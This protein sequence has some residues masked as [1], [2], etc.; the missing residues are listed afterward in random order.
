MYSPGITKRRGHGGAEVG[1]VSRRT[2]L[3]GAAAAGTL[4]LLAPASKVLG[5]N[6]R[7]RI[8]VCGVRGRGNG[9]MRNF[10]DIDGVE[11]AWIVDPDVRQLLQRSEQ[12]EERTGKKPQTTTDVRH[13]L[14]DRNV[15]AIV[16]GAPNHWHALM[17][18]WAA[19]AGKHCYVEK[20]ASHDVYEG[21]VALEE[22]LTTLTRHCWAGRLAP[23]SAI[24]NLR[25]SIH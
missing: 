18:I 17:V 2:L 8:A 11:V 13:A 9:L 5:A 20:P 14:E 7:F 21:R 25:Q 15:D 4:G 3:Q 19:Q 12:M 6:D 10:A 24:V 22:I 16:V 1:R 23:P